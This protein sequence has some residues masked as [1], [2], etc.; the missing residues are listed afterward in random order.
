M[1]K[2]ITDKRVIERYERGKKIIE[3]IKLV[4]EGVGEDKAGP[5]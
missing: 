1:D 2:I 5:G 4:L 3:G